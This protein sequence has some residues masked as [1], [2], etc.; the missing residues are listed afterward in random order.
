MNINT[1]IH[2]LYLSYPRDWKNQ[3]GKCEPFL[4]TFLFEMITEFPV[5]GSLCVSHRGCH[6]LLLQQ[7][8]N[9]YPFWRINGI[10]LL[11]ENYVEGKLDR[12]FIERSLPLLNKVR[13]H[14]LIDECD[15]E[16]WSLWTI[17]ISDY[18]W[19][20]QTSNSISIHFDWVNYLNEFEDRSSKV[21]S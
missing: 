13:V 16:S 11:D 7:P 10:K 17:F 5:G 4:K 2:F 9:E 12:V 14:E 19:H 20:L 8:R 3:Q 15:N 21:L 6:Q 18:G 1:C